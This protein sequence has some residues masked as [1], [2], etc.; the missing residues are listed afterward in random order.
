MSVEQ[1]PQENIGA[2]PRLYKRI[3]LF[4]C[5]GKIAAINRSTEK[6]RLFPAVL[7]TDVSSK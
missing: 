6:F 7:S 4:D 5:L 1:Q 2:L 3:W